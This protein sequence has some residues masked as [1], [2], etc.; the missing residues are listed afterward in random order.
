MVCPHG[1]GGLSQCGHFADKGE[2]VFFAISSERLLC[3]APYLFVSSTTELDMESSI[4]KP[5]K[6]FLSFN[7]KE[8]VECRRY[9]TLCNRHNKKHYLE[10]KSNHYT[11]LNTLSDV[12]SER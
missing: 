4:E 8:S 12:T 5:V 9:V 7:L 2:G 1:Q 6:T 11:L 10:K 3:T